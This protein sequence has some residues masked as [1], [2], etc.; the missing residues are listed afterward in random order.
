DALMARTRTRPLPARRLRP[1]DALLLGLLLLGISAPMLV[2]GV[3]LI[4][5]QLGLMAHVLYVLVYT[6]LKR[7]S[8]WSTM[9]GF[10][11]GAMPPLMGYTAVTGTLDSLGLALFLVLFVWQLPH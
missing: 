8:V 11:P 9:V 1:R 6:P 7:R 10:I 5:A 3:N 2:L 4:T